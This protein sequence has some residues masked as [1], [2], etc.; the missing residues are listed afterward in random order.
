MVGGNQMKITPFRG[1]INF[2]RKYYR[3][4]GIY[5]VDLRT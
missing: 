1:D 5:I 2:D 3:S 4:Y